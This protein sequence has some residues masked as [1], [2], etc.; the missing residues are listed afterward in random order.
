MIRFAAA[1]IIAL[2]SS[3]IAP[4]ATVS[5]AVSAQGTASPEAPAT[6]LGW[7]VGNWEGVGSSFGSPGKA[8]LGI[9]PALDG[10]F[11]ELAYTVSTSGPRGMRFQGRAFYRPKGDAAWD[12]RWFDSR[13]VA[14]DIAAK[15]DKSALTSD[16]GAGRDRG[17]TIYQLKDDGKLEVIDSV[18]SKDGS[19]QEFARYL[20]DKKS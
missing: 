1:L 18:V 8:Q 11:L 10:K 7:L 5:F 12:A 9:Q 19:M 6:Q 14:F 15:V 13:G 3:A 17:R 4:A 2:A 20:Y 16:W